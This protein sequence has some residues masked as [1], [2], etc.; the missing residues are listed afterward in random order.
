MYR[1]TRVKSSNDSS[2]MSRVCVVECSVFLFKVIACG[3]KLF[4][5]L[6]A[7]VLMDQ[8][9]LRVGAAHFHTST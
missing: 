6:V 3:E 4:L 7:F 2:H 8:L 5:S 9:S 1:N